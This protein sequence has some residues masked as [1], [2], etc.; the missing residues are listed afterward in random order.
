MV[1][2]KKKNNCSDVDTKEKYNFDKLIQ[3]LNEAMVK[4][5]LHFKNLSQKRDVYTLQQAAFRLNCSRN[6]FEKKFVKSGKIKL[7]IISGNKYVLDSE[8]QNYLRTEIK[9]SNMLK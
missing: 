5:E 4:P 8:I 6:E 9:K 1:K 2:I 3:S 7:Q